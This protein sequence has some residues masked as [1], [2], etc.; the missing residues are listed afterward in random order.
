VVGDAGPGDRGAARQVVGVGE[1]GRLIRGEIVAGLTI[2]LVGLPQCIAYALMSGVPPAYGLVTAAVPGLVAVLT[3]KS[4]QIITGPTNTTGLL[5]LAALSPYLGEG[6]VIGVEALPVLAT[7]TVLAGLIRIA[8][9]V[10][11]GAAILDFLPESVLTGFTSGAAVLIAT[12]QLDEGLGIEGVS[13]S[14]LPSQARA[15][16]S[17]I[18]DGSV[19]TVIAIA[20]TL[21]TVAAILI[22]KRHRPTWPVPLLIVL[23]GAGVAAGLG[24]HAASGLPI[25]AD[26]APVPL[27]WPPVALPSTDPMVW[28]V[29]ALPALAIVLLGTLEMTVSARAGGAMPDLRREIISQGAANVAGAF[30]GAFPASASLTRSA[31]LRIGGARTRLAPALSAVFIVPVLLFAAPLANQIPKASL[32]G[33]LYVT[34]LGMIDV[35]RIRRMLAV[36]GDTRL[37]LVATFVGT[38]VLPLEWAIVGGALF[39]LVRHLEQATRPRLRLYVPTAEGLGPVEPGAQP[40]LVVVEVSGTLHYAAIRNFLTELRARVPGSASRVVLDL[41]HAHHMR[42]AALA[43]FERLAADLEARGGRLV[44]AGVSGS[45]ADYLARAESTLRVFRERQ[46]AGES[47]REA[48]ADIS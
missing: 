4:H 10:A 37:L 29:L 16:A 30:T 40:P 39:G 46:H 6:G 43:A 23:A 48:L 26:Q 14:S 2:T 33:V 24:L 47:V 32:A 8:L 27:G 5:I 15:I 11:G 9:A 3:S 38:L 34:A 25:V 18:G 13:G 22:A 45:F 20:T 1:R 44:L 41:S 35:A 42:Y 21:I 7:L 31:L 12:M 17:A 19:P 28:E 36:G